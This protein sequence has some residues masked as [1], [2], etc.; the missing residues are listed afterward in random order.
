VPPA[1]EDVL[2]VRGAGEGVA[3]VQLGDRPG[4]VGGIIDE[5]IRQPESMRAGVGRRVGMHEHDGGTPL[6]L[7]EK[8][9]QNRVT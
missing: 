5:R 6:Q 1:C 4:G 3:V 8:R 7:I 2:D 9:L